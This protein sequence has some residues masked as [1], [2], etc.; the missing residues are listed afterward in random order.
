M[1]KITTFLL[2]ALLATSLMACNTLKK[3]TGQRDDSILPGNREEILPPESQTARD[4]EVTGKKTAPC[5]PGD[6]NCA[7]PPTNQETPEIDQESSTVQ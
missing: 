7:A 2:V 5:N 3:F 4:P 1:K 6:L